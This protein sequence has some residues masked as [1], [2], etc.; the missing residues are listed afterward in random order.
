M[1]LTTLFLTMHFFCFHF[2]FAQHQF[3]CATQM[4][5]NLTPYEKNALTNPSI[6]SGS[7]DPAYLATFEPICYNI[8]FWIINRDD[9]SNDVVINLTHIKENLSS[10]SYFRRSKRANCLASLSH[11]FK[12]CKLELILLSFLSQRVVV[13]IK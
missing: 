7:V 1:K 13:S 10:S 2:S 11:S 4:N 3:I 9:G 12:I 6:Y 5:Q 8:F